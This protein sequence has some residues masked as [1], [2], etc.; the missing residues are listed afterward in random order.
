MRLTRFTI[1]RRPM[2]PSRTIL[3]ALAVAF[4]FSTPVAAEDTIKRTPLQRLA[5]PETE[6]ETNIG[7]AEIVPDVLVGRHTHPGPESG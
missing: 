4:A 3:V 6:Y 1:V 7:I 5:V 2:I